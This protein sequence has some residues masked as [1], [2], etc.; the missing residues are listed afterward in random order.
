MVRLDRQ[1]SGKIALCLKKPE[2]AKDFR[3]RWTWVRVQTFPVSTR[4]ILD[5]VRELSEPLHPC[6]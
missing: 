6:L 2:S 5:E 4:V 1:A 3:V